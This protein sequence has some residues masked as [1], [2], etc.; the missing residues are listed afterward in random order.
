M[1]YN[2]RDIVQILL[3]AYEHSYGIRVRPGLRC[4][5][6]LSSNLPYYLSKEISSIKTVYTQ[7]DLQMRSLLQFPLDLNS[8][9]G[10]VLFNAHSSSSSSSFG[11]GSTPLSR[12]HP[13]LSFSFAVSG[14]Q[15][16]QVFL[17]GLTS[18]GGQMSAL[19]FLAMAS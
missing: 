9:Q 7:T 16:S 1:R 17:T 14:A 18:F 19:H 5:A 3:R 6:A 11:S 8:H 15:Q 2:V 4:V 12:V 13:S 10:V